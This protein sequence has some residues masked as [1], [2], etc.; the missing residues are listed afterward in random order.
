MIEGGEATEAGGA[1][2]GGG[3]AGEGVVLGEAA[4][5]IDTFAI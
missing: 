5:Y 4:G 3:E 1:G 2:T